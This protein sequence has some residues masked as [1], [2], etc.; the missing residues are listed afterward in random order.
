MAVRLVVYVTFIILP[1]LIV[2]WGTTEPGE[3]EPAQIEDIRIQTTNH[4]PEPAGQPV[5]KPESV[6][7]AAD[8]RNDLNVKSA[9]S[10]HNKSAGIWGHYVDEKGMVDYKTL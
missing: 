7:P 1:V 4:E 3:S 9:T 10:F 5:I 8:L 2:G 6:E